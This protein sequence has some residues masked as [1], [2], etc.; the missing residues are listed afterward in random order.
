[1]RQEETYRKRPG[2]ARVTFYAVNKGRRIR[3]QGATL[4]AVLLHLQALCPGGTFR[5][6]WEAKA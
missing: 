6:L 5:E 4:D 2:K 1:M 3:I